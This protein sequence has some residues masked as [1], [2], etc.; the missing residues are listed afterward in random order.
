MLLPFCTKE[1]SCQSHYGLIAVFFG[2]LELKSRWTPQP[3][4]I[5]EQKRNL[6]PLANQIPVAFNSMIA[7]SWHGVPEIN[8]VSVTSK[9]RHERNKCPWERCQEQEN[10]VQRKKR[11]FIMLVPFANTHTHI[12]INRKGQNNF[13]KVKDLKVHNHETHIYCSVTSSSQIS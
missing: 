8:N 9:L 11:Q 4:K 10:P 12:H 6:D 7:L 2:E 5:C 3:V 13:E 1:N